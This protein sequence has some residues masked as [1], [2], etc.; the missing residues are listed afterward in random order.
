ML[1]HLGKKQIKKKK[2]KNF[3]WQ[4]SAPHPFYVRGLRI[5]F[6]QSLRYLHKIT[7]TSLVYSLKMLAFDDLTVN[8]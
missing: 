2:K 4:L 7:I 5:F 3:R 1:D 6:V 8:Q